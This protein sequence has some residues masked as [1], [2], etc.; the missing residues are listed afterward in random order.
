MSQE[1]FVKGQNLS[2]F[3]LTLQVTDFSQA[4]FF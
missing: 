4:T 2:Y 1:E 3:S